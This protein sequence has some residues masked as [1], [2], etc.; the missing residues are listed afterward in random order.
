[1][2]SSNVL[3][4][5]TSSASSF[6]R[7]SQ[8]IE[9]CETQHEHCGVGR[10]VPLPKRLI[11]L[12]PIQNA[13]NEFGVKLAETENLVGTYASLSHCWGKEPMPMRT[14]EATIE[15]HKIFMP[16]KELPR[17]FQ[18][19]A[20]ISRR[21]GIRYLWIDSLCIIQD[22]TDDWQIESA[23]M[24]N[25]YR[26]SFITIAA[27]A[28]G[29]FRGGCF[30]RD[31]IGDTCFHVQGDDVPDGTV[32]GVRDSN[33][34]GWVHDE[35]HLSSFFT[36][37]TRAWIFQER[38][39]SRRVLYF[40]HGEL[41]LE[42]RQGLVCECDNIFILPHASPKTRAGMC[43]QSV[44]KQYFQAIKSLCL[45][46]PGDPVDTA[47]L[48]NHWQKA[49]M[50]YSKLHL[51]YP[52][53]KLPA[54]SGC[55]KD[56]GSYTGDQYLA[57]IWRHTFVQGM[58]WTVLGPVT[59][60]RP[61]WRAPSWSWASV[62]TPFG[63]HYNRAQS[64]RKTSTEVFLNRIQ[65][66][67]CV[68]D[69]KDNTGAVKS[70]SL[71]LKSSLRPVYVRRVCR[72]HRQ[73]GAKLKHGVTLESD[74]FYS[75]FSARN[76]ARSGFCNFSVP[77]LKLKND[78]L[79]LSPDFRY[80]RTTFGVNLDPHGPG[81]CRLAE[82]FLLHLFDSAARSSGPNTHFF[83]LLRK[84]ASSG[85][86]HFERTGLVTMVFSDVEQ[87][88]RWFE[89]VFRPEASEEKAITIN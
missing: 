8:W 21:L 17:T 77:R 29:D 47:A 7:A 51:T 70:A 12:D 30:A 33:G 48:N 23:K 67:D 45:G 68:P 62:D 52:G 85:E 54:L 6:D 18:D 73:G 49:V 5:D 63:L 40:N 14:L 78:M 26:N 11:D 38:L 27:A 3:N 1:M 15:P 81:S 36:M 83:L 2:P 71:R 46:S 65:S 74:M 60:P 25:I 55:A 87:A 64:R 44:K 39:L 13:D 88:D 19:A 35:S 84:I 37:F 56:F 76:H 4:G 53:D 82:A 16:W 61:T 34:L 66:I 9:A 43:M 32:I 79:S 72:A 75:Q 50:Q 22:S 24:A 20:N 41:Q 80:D 69:G 31:K 89:D 86:D 59:E 42:C 58:L 10:D 28:A 57:G